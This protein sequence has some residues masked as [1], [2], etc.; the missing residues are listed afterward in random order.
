ML[1]LVIFDLDDVLYSEREYMISGFRQVSKKLSKIK[2][3]QDE[4]VDTMIKIYEKDPSHV[5]DNL[6]SLVTPNVS[7]LKLFVQ[8]LLDIYRNHEPVISLYQ[9]VMPI[10]TN[11][12]NNCVKTAI[13]TDGH[14]ISQRL[15]ISSLELCGKID[16]IIIT[17]SL[18]PNRKY[19]KP[20]PY[21][22]KMILKKFNIKSNNSCYVGDN[23]KKDFEGP[24][25]LGIRTIQIKRPNAIYSKEIPKNLLNRPEFIIKSLNE[26][27]SLKL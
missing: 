13:I 26:L 25:M 8:E 18:G 1:E 27:N 2:K 3:D 19:W 9:D 15:K 22:F 4:L 11:L 6:F 16:H 10:L 5:F 23:V 14:E 12:K 20:N 24:N 17:D 7:N 21:S